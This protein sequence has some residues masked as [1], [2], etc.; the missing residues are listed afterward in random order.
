MHGQLDPC[1]CE[2]VSRSGSASSVKSEMFLA[3]EEQSTYIPVNYISD[4]ARAFI[5]AYET[6]AARRGA[7]V[8]NVASH[9]SIAPIATDMYE[10]ERILASFAP[11]KRFFRTFWQ[12]IS[13][14]L[15]RTEKLRIG[16]LDDDEDD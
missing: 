8:G 1:D 6:A 10:P 11:P 15:L 4:E 2:S 5:L 12:S 9:E 13:I 16:Q 3:N 7:A 14:R